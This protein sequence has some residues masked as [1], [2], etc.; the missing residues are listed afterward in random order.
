MSELDPREMLQALEALVVAESPSLDK[1]RC[2][3]CA[4]S[5]AALFQRLT[6]SSAR[7]HRQTDRGDHLEFRFGDG[8]EPILVLCHY[9]TVWDAGTLARLPFRQDGDRVTGPGCYDMKAGI[10]QTA[11]ALRS[12]RPRRPVVVLV[13]SDEEIGSGSSKPL[14]EDRAKT[15]AAVLVL[16]PA[17]TGGAIKTARKGIADYTLRVRGRAA[18]AGTEPEKGVS[19]IEELAHQILRLRDLADPTQG[20]TVNVGVI[21]GGTRPNVVA[22]EAQ[23]QIDVRLASAAETNRVLRAIDGLRP[24]LNGAVLDVTG[25]LDRPP[26]ERSEGVARLATLA[27]AIA[28]ELGFAL[29]ESS[30]GGG[31]DGNFT[32][33]LGVPTLDGL[34]PDGGGAHADSEHMLVSSWI[35]RTDLLSRLLERI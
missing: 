23:A 34:G 20:T 3:R 8:P 22:A 21:S 17:T 6:G 11:F 1:A 4:D 15:A 29:P 10:V 12:A 13:T 27:Q 33:A 16:E 7:R 24:V 19:A 32:A 25:G 18:H 30:V 9:D 31:S 14:I 28:G 2:D 5:V 26:L 35:Q